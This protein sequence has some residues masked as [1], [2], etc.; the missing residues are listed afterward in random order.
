MLSQDGNTGAA[1]PSSAPDPIHDARPLVNTWQVQQH[2]RVL[3][4]EPSTLH[5]RAIHWDKTLPQDKRGID[6]PPTRP[7]P[8]N[9]PGLEEPPWVPPLQ[10]LP[11]LQQQGFNIYL[12]A[13]GGPHDK[14]VPT[15]QFLF[16]EWDDGTLAEQLAH[17]DALIAQ[18]LPVPTM[19]L[20]SG[21]KSIHA[22]WRLAES[23]PAA[24]WRVLIRRLI[25][26]CGSDPTCK[27]PSR[28]MRLAGC[29]YISKEGGA[30][31]G[32][33]TILDA[34]I[35]RTS[36]PASAFDFLPD[37]EPP[38]PPVGQLP[39]PAAPA[40]TSRN[41]ANGTA[42]PRPYGEWERLVAAYPTIHADN[43]QRDEAVKVICGLIADMEAA[44]FT[45]AD[46]I[47]LADRH[48]PGAAD[49]FA[50][51]GRT[52]IRAQPGTFI[53][54]C[55]DKGV[56]ATRHDLTRPPAERPAEDYTPDDAPVGRSQGF[57]AAAGQAPGIAPQGDLKTDDAEDAEA[58]REEVLGLRRAAASELT[59]ADVLPESLAEP[60]TRLGEAYPADP[61]ALFL[62]LL[63][64]AAS[65]VG[66]RVRIYVKD[67]WDEPFLL[68]GV[69]I[70]QASAGKSPMAD[71]LIRPMTSWA[72]ALKE[73]VKGEMKAWV[74]QKKLAV[75]QAN[76]KKKAEAEYGI[77]NPPPPP[78][79]EL[80]VMDAT[81]E[82]LGSILNG[83]RTVGIVSF[84]DELST[85][86]A[87]HQ[88]SGKNGP[89][90]RS[91]WNS[92]W[93]GRTLKVDRT[94]TESYLIPNTAVSVFGSTTLDLMAIEHAK[95][96]K[97]NKGKVDPDGML[98]RFLVWVPKAFTWQFNRLSISTHDLLRN[99]YEKQLDAIVPP[100][101]DPSRPPML[102]FSAKAMEVME[103]LW[104]ELAAEAERSAPARAQWLGK[105]RG[106]SIRIAGVLHAIEQ[107]LKGL[108]LLT[109][110][111]AAN[112]IT[113]SAETARKAALAVV[114][115][116][117]KYDVLQ[118]H[119]GGREGILPAEVAKLLA[120][121]IEWRKAHGTALVTMT[122][123]RDWRVL[124][125][126]TTAPQRR[127]WVAEAVAKYPGMGEMVPGHK[128]D[129]W[130]PPA[131]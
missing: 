96:M 31:T 108:P 120:K 22:W 61:M 25:A 60:M 71:Y 81:L 32:Q 10:R 85:W 109:P 77:E 27:N 39:L 76:D 40:P 35:T 78:G 79:R 80:F 99:F 128:G 72:V 65:I 89:D 51:F 21:G 59:L 64:L 5:L 114:A 6:L 101:P 28:L 30:V 29:S 49:T 33:A 3:Q 100:C 121:G 84:H 87:Q 34:R 52:E 73:A 122:Q 54:L 67:S 117:D 9:I 4:L 16:V 86:F 38:A 20:W 62:P 50:Q 68:W 47:A 2:L 18:G 83:E 130:L 103:P 23:V 17:L 69:N 8:L 129:N 1:S 93:N 36:Y 43:D 102:H 37:P 111:G 44:G 113:I 112:P 116:I 94:T 58:L 106:N 104:N 56:D 118:A 123:I 41:G 92:L 63:T 115:F 124:D 45:R 19:V 95:A 26:F 55:K 74:A 66:N 90:H 46:A 131:G 110:P 53:N 70:A 125:A 97:E 12:L 98:A 105:M 13:N 7:K 57:R 82:K 14:D 88:R 11:A 75:D 48:H 91:N 107:A 42:P 126:G 127:A 119:I 15:C 24:D